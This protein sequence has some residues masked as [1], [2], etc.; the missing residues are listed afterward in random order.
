MTATVNTA[1]IILAVATRKSTNAGLLAVGLTQAVSLQDIITLML[2]S[3]TQLEI[4]AVALERN[5]EYSNLSPEEDTHSTVAV[6]PDA[7]WPSKG[8]VKFI[9]VFARYTEEAA[10]VLRGISFHAPAGNK[11]AIV[12]R[13]GGGKSTLLMALLRALH[14]EGEILSKQIFKLAS[15]PS[16][17]LFKSTASIS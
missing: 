12:G 11:F 3:W 4:S 17:N 1:I 6:M 9:D 13:T 14:T 10:P 16:S 15:V 2:T 5:L 7:A 8:D